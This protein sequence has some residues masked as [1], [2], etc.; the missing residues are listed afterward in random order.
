[1]YWGRIER[2]NI[3]REN[4]QR[5][6]ESLRRLTER[7]KFQWSTLR[8]TCRQFNYRFKNP[9]QQFAV[10]ARRRFHSSSLFA[11]NTLDS[12]HVVRDRSTTTGRKSAAGRRAQNQL[13]Y[14]DCGT[15]R[16]VNSLSSWLYPVYTRARSPCV[17]MR[18]WSL[19]FLVKPATEWASTN[20]GG[21]MAL[22]VWIIHEDI[23]LHS[24]LRRVSLPRAPRAAPLSFLLSRI[25]SPRPPFI[26]PETA[27]C[28][29]DLL[30]PASN[31]SISK[32]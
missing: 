25:Y 22:E 14:A 18:A 29:S 15:A 21:S 10:S 32:R 17:C 31:I 9:V 28:L 12:Y 20:G 3:P 7:L 5:Y 2:E 4:I 8:K 13:L 27:S 1:M 16:N 23:S 6:F 24:P 26:R 19:D 30:T 11:A